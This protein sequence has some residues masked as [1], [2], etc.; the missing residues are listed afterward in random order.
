MGSTTS[1]RPPD[2]DDTLP[3]APPAAR[4]SPGSDCE[5]PCGVLAARLPW[6]FQ[7]AL[8]N[9]GAMDVAVAIALVAF[10][11]L[12]LVRKRKR[13][14]ETTTDQPPSD[15]PSAAGANLGVQANADTS[16]E[17][18]TSE[19]LAPIRSPRELATNRVLV[20]VLETFDSAE[21]LV[22]KSLLEEAAIPYYAKGEAVQD[23]FGIGR[24]FWGSNFVTGPVA[25]QVPAELMEA[26]RTALSDPEVSP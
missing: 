9:G 15:E 10:V 22:A 26:A 21:L 20:T 7:A 11:L 23:L 12:L 18:D 19:S 2:F 25:L 1:P 13:K 24:L 8:A 5:T 4:S 14:S 6:C 17:T 16:R 3:P